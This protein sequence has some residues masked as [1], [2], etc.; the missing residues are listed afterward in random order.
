M[1][2]YSPA[3]FFSWLARIRKGA[4]TDDTFLTLAWQITVLSGIIVPLQGLFNPSVD[5]A[6]IMRRE[7]LER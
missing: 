3:S 2:N 1:K 4:T 7:R 5:Q 6:K